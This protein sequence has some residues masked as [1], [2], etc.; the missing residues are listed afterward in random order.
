MLREITCCFYRS[1]AFARQRVKKQKN[2]AEPEAPP[3]DDKFNSWE[4]VNNAVPGKEDV[5]AATDS[6]T[7]GKDDFFSTIRSLKRN[8]GT[9]KNQP[10]GR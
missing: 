9:L 4:Q 6:L 3:E 5:T 10:K 1:A 7:D 2:G 8:V